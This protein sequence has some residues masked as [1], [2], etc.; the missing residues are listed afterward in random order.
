M[1]CQAQGTTGKGQG[2][3]TRILFRH[4]VRGERRQGCCVFIPLPVQQTQPFLENALLH[5]RHL[6][7]KSR[8]FLGQ[9]PKTQKDT[10]VNLPN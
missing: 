5:N 9:K 7:L 10:E 3:I 2:R 6:K 4:I 1:K 8:L